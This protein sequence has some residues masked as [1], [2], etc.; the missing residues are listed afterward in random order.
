MKFRQAS[1]FFE[2]RLHEHESVQS[3]TPVKYIV[4]I[5]LRRFLHNNHPSLNSNRPYCLVAQ[6]KFDVP[7]KGIL[8]FHS[9]THQH[10]TSMQPDPQMQSKDWIRDK[11]QALRRQSGISFNQDLFISILLC[12]ISGS[13]RHLIL[14]ASEDQ[15]P[16]VISMTNKVSLKPNTFTGL[17]RNY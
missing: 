12:L 4:R 6:G 1:L 9:F 15:L 11:I 17:K 14:T 10:L 13:G 2:I 5:L 8:Q 16:N 3:L 7:T